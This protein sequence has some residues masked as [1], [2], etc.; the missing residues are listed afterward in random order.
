MRN[1]VRDLANVI[2]GVLT[3]ML[4][5]AGCTGMMAQRAPQTMEERALALEYDVQATL[6]TASDMID[7]G[8]V[9]PEMAKAVL[10]QMDELEVALD[11]ARA[12]MVRQEGVPGALALVTQLNTQLILYLQQ[13]QEPGHEN[14]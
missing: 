13:H 9:T 6:H 2:F 8:L 10:S 4:F 1:P 11:A 3:L 5:L 7:T 14:R 12:A